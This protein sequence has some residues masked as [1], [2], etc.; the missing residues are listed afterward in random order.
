M[1]EK[2]IVSY[3]CTSSDVEVDKPNDKNYRISIYGSRLYVAYPAMFQDDG[4]RWYSHYINTDNFVI[5][6]DGK[7]HYII[8][9]GES[10]TGQPTVAQYLRDIFRLIA[11]S[12]WTMC[13]SDDNVINGKGFTL[14]E[15]IAEVERYF[16]SKIIK[17]T[18]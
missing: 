17:Q 7:L 5:G 13:D 18:E 10:A 6:M 1:D 15:V 12:K 3:H 2:F 14:D 16:M 11:V 9:D 4:I 8:R